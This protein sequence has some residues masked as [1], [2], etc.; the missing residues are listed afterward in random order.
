M[1]KLKIH[2]WFVAMNLIVARLST[3]PKSTLHGVT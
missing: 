2:L 1:E 3:R